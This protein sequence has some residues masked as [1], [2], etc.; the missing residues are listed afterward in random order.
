MGITMI[1]ASMPAVYSDELTPGFNISSPADAE[2]TKNYP[3]ESGKI[4]EK[5]T[6]TIS[7]QARSAKEKAQVEQLQ[8]IDKEVQDHEAAHQAAAGNLFLGKTF[9]YRI[10]PDGNRYAVA[11]E[12]NIDTSAVPGN[13][14]ATIDKMERIKSAAMA[15]GDPSAQ[16]MKVAAAAASA[17][18][19]A[20]KE[21]E[22]SGTAP[23]TSNSTGQQAEIV[24]RNTA[25]PLPVNQHTSGTDESNNNQNTSGSINLTISALFGNNQLNSNEG[26]IIDCSM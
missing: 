16:D 18:I 26:K 7:S 21:L 14:K 12:V 25:I 3:A 19:E 6:A 13:P 11:G 4:S 5:D 15:P 20:R 1:D 22:K 10:G 24:R 17:E 2:K 9:T 23:G 8:K